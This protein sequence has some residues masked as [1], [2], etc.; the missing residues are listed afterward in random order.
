MFS[1]VSAFSALFALLHLHLT[2]R[3][4]SRPGD[5]AAPHIKVH[6]SEPLFRLL[7]D[8]FRLGPNYIF[9]YYELFLTMPLFATALGYCIFFENSEFKGIYWIRS[10]MWGY[11]LILPLIAWFATDF[12]ISAPGA[13]NSLKANRIISDESHT[14]FV[15]DANKFYHEKAYVALIAVVTLI[16]EIWFRFDMVR[17]HVHAFVLAG[18]INRVELLETFVHIVST[19]SVLL[20]LVY[21]TATLVLLTQVLK[22]SDFTSLVFHE[23]RYVG[24]EE[25][26]HLLTDFSNIVLLVLVEFILTISDAIRLHL[27]L[28]MMHLVVFGFGLV[29]LPI[30]T[31]VP[32]WVV[33]DR[34]INARRTW[35]GR[36]NNWFQAACGVSHPGNPEVSAGVPYQLM[37]FEKADGIKRAIDR[38]PMWPLPAYKVGAFLAKMAFTLVAFAAAI[39]DIVR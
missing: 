2:L 7:L 17:N 12:Y 29:A 32:I 10:Q 16:A 8:R 11:A 23:D 38:I 24:I 35:M 37:N 9:L 36:L 19:Y 4:P 25:V 1:F 15:K 6:G 3:S 13:I 39:M 18:H 28:A 14:Q 26:V 27:P 33:H 34:L 5:T 31:F 20:V 21:G 30:L 22:E